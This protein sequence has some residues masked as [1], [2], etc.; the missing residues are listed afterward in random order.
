VAGAAIKQWA[1]H[2][3]GEV[4]DRTTGMTEDE[5]RAAQEKG[6]S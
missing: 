4:Q 5:R 3:C 6:F 1:E 2:V